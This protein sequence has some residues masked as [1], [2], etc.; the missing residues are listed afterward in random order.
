MAAP[1]L[2][3]LN[4][5][6]GANSWAEARAY[7]HPHTGV[8]YPSVTS[9]LKMADKSSLTQWAVNL[10]VDWAVNNIDKL[11]SM[12]VERGANVARYRWKDVR[13]ERAEVGTGVHETIEA[14]LTGSW[15]YPELDSEQQLI[16]EEWH[17]F[18]E[19]HE[20]ELMLSEF[21]VFD[22]DSKSMG[23]ADGYVLIDGVK[24]LIDLKTSKSMWPEHE[25]QLA[26]LWHAEDWLVET[27][28]MIWTSIPKREVEQVAIIHLRAPEFD[29]W[30]RKIKEG[31]HDL[32]PITNLDLNYNVYKAYSDVWYARQAI[33]DVKKEEAKVVDG[34]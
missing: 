20:V 28:E 8:Q 25:Y 34:F 13:D 22:K 27:E 7:R 29:D 15:N 1:K 10:S 11:L 14:E 32:V 18:R 5:W 2:T 33:A 6:G 21:T 26:A 31:K 3:R 4:L 23:T 17:K 30:G 19:E 9:I 16:M 12:S 24:T